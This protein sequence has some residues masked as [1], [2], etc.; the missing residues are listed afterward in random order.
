[1]SIDQPQPEA[2]RDKNRL[3]FFRYEGSLTTPACDEI[4]I[5]SVFESPIVVSPATRVAMSSWAK[6]VIIPIFLITFVID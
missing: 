2:L 4:V 5:W 6:E 1:M 3:Y